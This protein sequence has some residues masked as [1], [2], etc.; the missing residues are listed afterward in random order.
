VDITFLAV[1]FVAVTAFWLLGLTAV[2][3]MS[4]LVMAAFRFI[5]QRWPEPV[6]V[7]ASEPQRRELALA[8]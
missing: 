3:L 7:T 5:A 2:S 1:A 4:L 6:A 8:S